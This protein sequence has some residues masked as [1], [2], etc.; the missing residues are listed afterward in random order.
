MVSA[1]RASPAVFGDIRGAGQRPIFLPFLQSFSLAV[2]Y[3]HGG[4]QYSTFPRDSRGSD[5]KHD[6]SYHLPKRGAR[7]EQTNRHGEM[8]G[9][10]D[11]LHARLCAVHEDTSPT[12]VQRTWRRCSSSRETFVSLFY[13]LSQRRIVC[14][15]FFLTV[16]RRF[17]VTERRM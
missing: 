1:Q 14:A 16:W 8:E 13:A 9:G 5:G 2:Q 6:I 4:S 11:P 17:R 15:T 3:S 12:V 10:R 7:R